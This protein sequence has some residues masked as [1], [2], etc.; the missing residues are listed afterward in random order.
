[1][2]NMASI[3]L[4]RLEAEF[5][6]DFAAPFALDGTQ[7]DLFANIDDLFAELA[8]LTD[9]D[10]LRPDTPV[11]REP[12]PV[13]PVSPMPPVA[14]E[15]TPVDPVSPMPPVAREPTPTPAP[16]P[17]SCTWRVDDGLF[18]VPADIKVNESVRRP[19]KRARTRRAPPVMGSRATP[20]CKC[21]TGCAKKYCPC[22]KIGKKC[23]PSTC[24][25]CVGSCC[26]TADS[27]AKPPLGHCTCKA[28]MCAKNYCECF[29]SGRT[30]GHKCACAVGCQNCA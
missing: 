11:A 5:N 2:D 10:V 16:T 25:T 13:D 9:G 1:M 19:R 18:G 6:D 4:A 14:R 30:C 8:G 12:T 29:A 3:D 15:P 28:S 27:V 7:G 17:L 21:S 23:D 22:V 24:R 20:G 26:N